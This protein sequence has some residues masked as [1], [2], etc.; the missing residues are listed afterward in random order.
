MGIFKR[1]HIRGMAHEL[2][3]QGLVTWP[4][5]LAEE[6]TADAIADDTEEEEV[7]EVTEESGLTEEQAAAALQKIV[8]VAEEI[9]AKTGGARDLGINKTAAATDY[10]SAASQTA[11]GLMQ[12]AAEE[13]LLQL[14]LMFLELPHQLRIWEP[15][16]KV[17]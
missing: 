16:R 2:T 11:I 10:P 9:A 17:K 3:V 7:P 1:A 15:L 8:Q 13:R 14:V 12:K 4:S 6:E 5:K